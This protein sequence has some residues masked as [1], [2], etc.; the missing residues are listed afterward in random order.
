VVLLVP[1]AALLAVV[2]GQ[3]PA[4]PQAS[5][6]TVRT[7]CALPSSGDT[8]SGNLAPQL[9]AAPAPPPPPAAKAAAPQDA[10]PAPAPHDGIRTLLGGIVHDFGQLPTRQNLWPAAAGTAFSLAARPFDH[11]LNPHLAGKG[12]VHRV[13][14]PGKYIGFG[15][16][17]AAAAAGM[18]A[19]GHVGDRP[20]ISGLGADL[21]RAHAI[22]AALTYGLQ[23]AVR[24]ERPDTSDVY[25]FPSGH[26]SMTF[27][28]ATV[29]ERRFGWRAGIPM[30]L[31]AS[32]VATSRLHENR[33]HLSDVVAGA[34]LG[35]IVGRTVT[36]G[37][38]SWTIVPARLPAGFA[39][40]I[41]WTAAA[42]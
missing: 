34:T 4:A 39:L 8:S 29:L 22:T 31:I 19:V 1:V 18:F 20:K 7:V 37:R 38:S 5:T 24:R 12:N 15:P 36:R 26:S 17:Q 10:A 30:Y 21:L 23:F 11:S 13:F 41:V 42:R 3:A 25:S 9:G 28:T 16:I 33:H 35:I 2:A 6:A 27:A 14:L 32:Y 40:V